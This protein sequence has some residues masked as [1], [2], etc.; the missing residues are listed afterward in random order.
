MS[1]FHR[2][3]VV[4]LILGLTQLAV[5]EDWKNF[6]GPGGQG[7]SAE[8]GLPTEWSDDKNIEWKIELPG[9]GSSSP[10][11]LGDKLFVTAFSG[12]GLK[13]GEGSME[14]LRLHLVCL[15]KNTGSKLWASEVKPRLPES[16]KVRDHGYTAATPATDGEHIYVFF[17][18]S[19]VLKFDLNGKQIWQTFVGEGL[20]GWG[21]GTSPV[22]YEDLVIVNAS[23]E[24]G[25]IVAI[26]KSTGKEKWRA[27]DMK[28]SWSTPHLV[29]VNDRMELVASSKDYVYGYDPATG[30]K[31]WTAEGI[32]D[33]VCPSIV[34]NQGIVY[35]IGG[36]QSQAVAIKAGQKGEAKELW[37]ANVGANV[38]SPCVYKDHLY[39][40]SDRNTVAYCLRLS[41]GE[42]VYRNRFSSQPY[43]SSII[44][45]GKIFVVT[46]RGGT[47]V[48]EASPEFKELATNKLT[49]EGQF[50]ASP[51][52]SDGKLY[53]RSDTSLYCIGK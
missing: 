42:M 35:V 6:R 3:I 27:K 53:I 14:D 11:T 41:D 18:K 12:Y 21:C 31:L 36:R 13:R 28:R 22:L 7:V 45:D 23:V 47:V 52:V 44:A 32:H 10:I 49:D 30:E 50:N 16:K 5:A 26:E 19:G 1:M 4:T 15:D 24:S 51:I 34:S 46:R 43:A 17:G 39:W 2:L 8:K 20:H 37:R 38:S 33:Y 48:L 9:A 40:V 25:A 29:K